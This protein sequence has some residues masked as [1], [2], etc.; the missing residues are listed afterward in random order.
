MNDISPLLRHWIS[1][2]EVT[3]MQLIAVASHKCWKCC[4]KG[5]KRK[6]VTEKVVGYKLRSVTYFLHDRFLITCWIQLKSIIIKVEYFIYHFCIR[7]SKKKIYL[8]CICC[9]VMHWPVS[10]TFPTMSKLWEPGCV[11][12]QKAWL[13]SWLAFQQL[14]SS[15]SP[16]PHFA[17]CTTISKRLLYWLRDPIEAEN[18]YCVLNLLLELREHFWRQSADFMLIP[19]C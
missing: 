11:F 4:C 9:S 13:C 17:L 5:K 2:F 1:Q 8:C 15:S 6:S 10:R 12:L 7:K 14:R 19:A 16:P 3:D 18:T